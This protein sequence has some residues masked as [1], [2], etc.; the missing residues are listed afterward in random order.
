VF[1][2]VGEGKKMKNTVIE[3]R[4][5]SI[6]ELLSLVDEKRADANQTRLEAGSN[7][8]KDT[9]VFKKT[10]QEVARLMTV[11]SEKKRSGHVS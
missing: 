2:D 6:A 8:Q 3:F 4:K 7:E 5:K 10:R 11:L 1:H 9:S